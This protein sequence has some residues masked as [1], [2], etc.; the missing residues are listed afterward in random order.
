ML[1]QD[2]PTS[3]RNVDVFVEGTEIV[4]DFTSST[5]NLTS[6]RLITHQ[7]TPLDGTLNIVLSGANQETGDRNPILSALTLEVVPEPGSL[8]LL[9]LAVPAL[10]RRTGRR[11]R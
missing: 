8:A 10:L 7:F 11:G 5:G 9:G 3:D 6:G 4:S 2:A 1:F